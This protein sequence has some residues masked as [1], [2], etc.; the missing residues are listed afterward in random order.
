[1]MA[2]WQSWIER[3]IIALGIGCFWPW[4]LGVRGVWYSAALVAVFAAL[5]VLAA[6]RL[7]RIKNALEHRGETADVPGPCRNATT[8][9]ECICSRRS[10][11]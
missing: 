11:S 10:S 2:R 9:E 4:I 8:E 7:R 3:G 6:I 1:M 5:A